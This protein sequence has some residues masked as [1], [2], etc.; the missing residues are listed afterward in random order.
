MVFSCMLGFRNLCTHMFVP[1]FSAPHM[2][3]RDTKL[4]NDVVR[5]IRVGLSLHSGLGLVMRRS[6]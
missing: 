2:E 1:D 5:Q 3:T 6:R 4:T